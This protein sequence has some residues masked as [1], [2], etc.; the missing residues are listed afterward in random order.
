MKYRNTVSFS[1]FCEDLGAKRHMRQ[2]SWSACNPDKRLG[3]FTVWEDEV[4]EGR[5]YIWEQPSDTRSAGRNEIWRFLNEVMNNG[6]DAYGILIEPRFD[7]NGKKT[8]KSF[9]ENSLRILDL[10]PEGSSIVGYIRGSVPSEAIRQG[11]SVID[12][13]DVSAINDIGSDEIGNDDP[14]YR[15][16]IAGSYV[17]DVKVR[18]RVLKRANGACEECNQPGFLKSDGKRY[19][20]THHVISLSEQG[21]D[22]PHNVIALCATDHRRAHYAENWAELQDKFLEKLKIY[23]TEK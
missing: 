22:K 6:H 4:V 13:L 3:L 12:A 23:K 21:S 1:Q 8:I 7:A 16:R 14:E 5:S 17:R 9:D 20:E 10:K 18:E 2:Q 11:L 19:L 15:K